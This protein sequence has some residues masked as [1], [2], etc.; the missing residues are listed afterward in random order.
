MVYYRDGSENDGSLSCKS[1][2]VVSSEREHNAT[3][4]I[5]DKF[6]EVL[7]NPLKVLPNLN[8]VH[9]FSDGAAAA[10]TRK[11]KKF[12]N[13]ANHVDDFALC[14]CLCCLEFFSYQSW[15]D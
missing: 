9:Y 15:E 8:H 7:M 4:I 3:C 14:Q 12:T 5:V 10:S 6:I 13:L 2:C 1:F 11:Y